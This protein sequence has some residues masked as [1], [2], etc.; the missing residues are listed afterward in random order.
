MDVLCSQIRFIGTMEILHIYTREQLHRLQAHTICI[1]LLYNIAPA[2]P[3]LGCHV[4]FQMT[5]IL[6]HFS[7]QLCPIPRL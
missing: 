6:C 1:M 7:A 2:A 4:I 5:V 3:Q